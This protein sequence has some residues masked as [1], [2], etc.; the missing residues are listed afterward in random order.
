MSQ[1]RSSSALAVLLLSTLLG[2][3]VSTPLGRSVELPQHTDAL[4]ARA[5]GDRPE[6]WVSPESLA[7][8]VY[9]VVSGPAGQ[10][11]DW[12]R[13]RALFRDGASFT[14][15]AEDGAPITFG[16]NEYI[17]WYGPMFVKRGIYE[18]EIWGRTDRSRRIAH[19][20]STEEYRWDTA[21]DGPPVGRSL[22]SM[23]FV[24]D[25][26]R[27]WITGMT[28][29]AE[30]DLNPI[31]PRHLPIGGDRANRASTPTP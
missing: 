14:T 1:H 2:C 7:A 18:R 20:W 3:R 26:T 28:W 22:V 11:R 21:G 30:D 19:R 10:Q 8:A 25:G 12:D 6:D 13:Y 4:A 16:V 15:L 23:Q 29:E 24:N 27:W 31:P 5:A 9:S 17:E